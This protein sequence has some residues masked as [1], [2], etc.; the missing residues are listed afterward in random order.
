M[1]KY[2]ILGFGTVGGGLAEVMAEQRE[3]L[4]AAAG[5]ELELAYI[6]VRRDLPDSPWRDK[7]V[8]DFSIIENDPSVAVVAEV[9]GGATAAYEYSRRAILA[10][11][12]VVSSNKE[13][14]AAHG[15]ELAA[16]AREH[17]V[18]YLFEGSVGGGI[19]LLRPLC[20][21]LAAN[22]ID[23]VYGILNGTTNYILTAMEAQ[24]QSFAEA[25]KKAQE[26]GYAEADPT[27]D[28]EG[29]DACRKTAILADLAFGVN[30]DPADIPTRGI[31]AVAPADLELAQALGGAV[32]L[33]GRAARTGESVCAFVEPHFIPQGHILASV[34]GVMNGCA[35]RGSAVGEVVLCGPGAG[36]HPTASAVA[37]D[38][39]DAVRHRADP[40][41][42]DLGAPG[43]RLLPADELCSRWYVRAQCGPEAVS[44]A[45]PG[46][47]PVYGST[48]ECGF[49]TAAMLDRRQLEKKLAAVNGRAAYRVLA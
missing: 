36:S 30:V 28:V 24:G 17:N 13:L 38:V 6:L 42:P 7:L 19:P 43:G 3:K 31:T 32:K 14:V 34:N 23:E 48:G 2:A 22:R 15:L 21:C 44:A 12:S 1:V 5:D 29:I 46:A 47:E 41:I 45:F 25:L 26:L 16:L 33:L 4:A 37:A 40:M 9:M 10:G 39:A 49:V 20:R 35:I 18:S 11:K 8:R 27:A